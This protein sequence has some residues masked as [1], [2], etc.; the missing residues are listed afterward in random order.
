MFCCN[1]WSPGGRHIEELP[2][3]A[4]PEQLPRLLELFSQFVLLNERVN[5]AVRDEQVF[6]SVIVEVQKGRPPF[7]ILG[8]HRKTGRTCDVFEVAIPK[9][10]I[11]RIRVAG[12]IGLEDVQISVADWK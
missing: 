6:P 1:A 7:H 5:V 3:A 2:V 12:E 10:S 4:I 9:V 8:V 11:K